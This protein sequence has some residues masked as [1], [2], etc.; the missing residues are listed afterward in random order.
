MSYRWVN[1]IKKLDES[2]YHEL[3][4][5]QEEIFSYHQKMR[6]DLFKEIPF[7]KEIYH[8]LVHHD[9]Y[10]IY[11][12]FLEEELLGV[13][14]V[15]KRGNIYYI[16]DIVV[17]STYQNQGIATAL[18]KYVEQMALKEGIDR[19][20]LDVWSFNEKAIRF[21]QKMGYTPKTIR[22]EKI[23]KKR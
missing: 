23:L 3:Y 18:F 11:A 6:S 4:S 2:Y 1:M 9:Q 21:Y 22:Y 16:D 12:Y 15:N 19:I 10:A 20:E 5:L 8:N 14:Y 7:S 17:K 13:I